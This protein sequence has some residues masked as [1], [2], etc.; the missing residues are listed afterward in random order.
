TP[1][2]P[3]LPAAAARRRTGP[4]PATAGRRRTGRGEWAARL[5]WLTSHG[6]TAKLLPRFIVSPFDHAA[7]GPRRLVV[8]RRRPI[9]P[10]EHPYQRQHLPGF[11]VVGADPRQ[12]RIATPLALVRLRFVRAG[13]P[14]LI[15]EM[16]D[17]VLPRLA[18]ADEAHRRHFPG[19]RHRVLV[20]G[21]KDT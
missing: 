5:S 3:P 6:A 8:G 11:P 18:P 9:T 17:P 13:D 14:P 7:V 21:T 15:G 1:A 4:R 16:G 19:P 20:S 2:E 12:L 10:P